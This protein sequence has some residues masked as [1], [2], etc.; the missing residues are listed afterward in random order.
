VRG[1][2]IAAQRRQLLLYP[3][4]KAA[5]ALGKVKDVIIFHA[6]RITLPGVEPVGVLER[7]LHEVICQQAREQARETRAELWRL[8]VR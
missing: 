7:D 1:R 2:E 8:G 5:A 4:G 6:L 3:L